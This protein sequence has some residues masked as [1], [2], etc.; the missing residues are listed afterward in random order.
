MTVKR[1]A[2]DPQQTKGAALVLTA[3]RVLLVTLSAVLLLHQL[4]AP[5]LGP[6]IVSAVVADWL[7]VSPAFGGESLRIGALGHQVLLDALRAFLRQ[8]LVRLR[9][10]LVVGVALDGQLE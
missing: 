9:V 4:H 1:I 3:D 8:R 10:A 6:T 2:A 7:G 5:V